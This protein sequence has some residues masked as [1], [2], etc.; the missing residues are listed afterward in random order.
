MGLPRKQEKLPH[1]H[2]DQEEQEQLKVL[3]CFWVK[4]RQVILFIRVG[5]HEA[6]KILLSSVSLRERL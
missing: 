6:C 2:L 1:S 5:F 4:S 3:L